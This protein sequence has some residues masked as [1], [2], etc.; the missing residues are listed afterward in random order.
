MKARQ[1]RFGTYA[2][3]HEPWVMKDF[4]DHLAGRITYGHY[5]VGTDDS[6]KLFAL[7]IDLEKL[8]EKS[9][10]AYKPLYLPT[11]RDGDGIFSHFEEK[12]PRMTWM[13][14]EPGP[15]R[16]F[17]R[18]KFNE[19]ANKFVRTVED[20]LEIKAVAAY[21]GSKGIHIYGFTGKASATAIRQAAQLVVADAG[22]VLSKGKNI[23]AYKADGFEIDDPGLDYSQF[24]L[25]VYPKQD[26]LEGK[27]KGLGNLMRLPLGVNHKSPKKDKPFFIDLRTPLN[28]LAPMDPI[29]ALTT[30]NIWAYTNEL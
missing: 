1:S 14:R 4:L 25:E 26:T 23:Y 5:M 28:D 27:E 7:D 24:S 9:S 22:W 29:E 12:C 10:R 17:I 11:Q 2:P 8:E 20:V 19:L 15:A 30:P 16:E 3:V 18:L 6:A 21:S 13:S